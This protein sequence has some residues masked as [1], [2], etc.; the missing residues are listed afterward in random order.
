MEMK[1]HQ[2]KFDYKFHPSSQTSIEIAEHVHH[3]GR[4]L[5]R[6]KHF[7]D[8]RHGCAIWAKYHTITTWH[9]LVCSRQNVS[10]GPLQRW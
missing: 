10:M 4:R 3:R 9:I 5:E 2:T 1:E 6:G 7:Q 8:V